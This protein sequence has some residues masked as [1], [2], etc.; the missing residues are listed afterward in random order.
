[1]GCLETVFPWKNLVLRGVK[2]T[3]R[4]KRSSH[5]DN[6]SLS[7]VLISIDRL[8][9]DICD[10]ES[11]GITEILKTYYSETPGSYMYFFLLQGKVTS[12]YSPEVRDPRKVTLPQLH[13]CC[14]I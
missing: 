9:F 6:A 2:K 3:L 7:R 11:T 1:M 14:F 13:I 4:V 8:S 5:F 10:G 12:R